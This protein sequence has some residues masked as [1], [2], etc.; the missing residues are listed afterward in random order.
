MK[1]LKKNKAPEQS[2]GDTSHASGRNL[3]ELLQI[4]QAK[5][6]SAFKDMSDIEQRRVWFWSKHIIR[7]Y[8]V[9]LERNPANIR[10]A[11]DLPFSKEEV[12]LA[13]KLALPFYAQKNIQSMVRN[14]RTI[15]KELGCFQSIKAEDKAKL[16]K[17]F[18]RRDK[19]SPMPYRELFK[20]HEKY[21]ETVISEKK[22][23]LQEIT[24][25]SNKFKISN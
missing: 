1:V 10:A 7:H 5:G 22:S 24:V 14:L 21:M 8:R 19:A 17:S 11:D 23:L 25:Y 16:R 6:L 15:Y 9:V 2:A 3:E 12:K 13:I 18:N 20:I 4:L